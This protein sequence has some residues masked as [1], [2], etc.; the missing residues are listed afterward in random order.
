MKKIV[1]FVMA[2]TLSLILMICLAEADGWRQSGPAWWYA[3]DNGK[4]AANQWLFDQKEWYYFDTDG[5]MVTD[6]KLI[7]GKWYYFES[8]GAMATEMKEIRNRQYYFGSDGA[9]KTGWQMIDENWHYFY[10]DGSM[11]VYTMID[12]YYLD[13]DGCMDD[14]PLSKIIVT[15]I[16][17]NSSDKPYVPELDSDGNGIIN[18]LDYKI[19]LRRGE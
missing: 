17:D 8:D 18:A 12:G 10:A 7:S 5:W 1:L 3:Y 4:Y 15:Y 9:M 11:A 6:W 2:C 14:R 19:A 16:L 13:R